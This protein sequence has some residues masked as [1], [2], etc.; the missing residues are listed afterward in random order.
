VIGDTLTA[1]AL[2]GARLICAGAFGFIGF[3]LAFHLAGF[4]LAILLL[5]YSLIY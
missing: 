4:S 5:D 2:S 1:P 3:N